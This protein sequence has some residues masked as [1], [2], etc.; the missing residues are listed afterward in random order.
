[1]GLMTPAA[2]LVRRASASGRVENG[3]PAGARDLCLEADLF[4]G[5]RQ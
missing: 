1:M 4:D 3:F 2:T 5:L